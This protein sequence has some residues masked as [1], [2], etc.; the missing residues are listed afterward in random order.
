L[1]FTTSN[2]ENVG[3]VFLE[4][5][6]TQTFINLKLDSLYTYSHSSSSNPNNRFVIHFTNGVDHKVTAETCA[7][8]NNGK[9]EAVGYGVGPWTYTWKDNTGSIITE[10]VNNSYEAELKDLSPGTYTVEI[11]D[12]SSQCESYAQTVT[13]EK[14]IEVT[15]DFEFEVL[16]S[17]NGSTQ[18]KFTNASTN[19]LQSTWNFG[20]GFMSTETNPTA[21]FISEGTYTIALTSTNNSCFSTSTK[22]ISISNGTTSVK[23]QAF[24]SVK[25]Y[26]LALSWLIEVENDEIE[27]IQVTSMSG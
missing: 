21:N 1:R 9:I 14:G 2:F 20:N 12:L 16:E 26:N 19:Y 8:S 18:I 17:N 4:D 23:E 22:S 13:I 7:N 24:S 11:T 27:T 3:C 25:I 5:K 10:D 6:E 15:S